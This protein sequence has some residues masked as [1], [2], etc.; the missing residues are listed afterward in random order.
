MPSLVPRAECRVRSAALRLGGR[1]RRHAGL[2]RMPESAPSRDAAVHYVDDVLRPVALEQARGHP[3]TPARAAHRGNRAFCFDGFGERV[4][5][6]PRL[7]LGA[8]DVPG[9]P[10]RDLADIEDLRP[11]RAL[12]VLPQP[13]E[14]EALESLDGAPLAPP[15]GHPTRQVPAELAHA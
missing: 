14:L 8:G 15:F 4:D 6:V 1:G 9:L 5:V 2:D 7:E 10:L 12:E 3:R 13:L 11:G